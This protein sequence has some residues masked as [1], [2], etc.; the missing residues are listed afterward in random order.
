MI[1]FSSDASGNRKN[2]VNK[3]SSLQKSALSGIDPMLIVFSVSEEFDLLCP[4]QKQVLKQCDFNT[5]NWIETNKTFIKF[6]HPTVCGDI[7]NLTYEK[8]NNFNKIFSTDNFL[9]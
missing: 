3:L 1:T 4:R 9:F 5:C 2:N 8:L 6:T 7:K